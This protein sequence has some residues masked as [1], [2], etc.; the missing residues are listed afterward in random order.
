M[1][2]KSVNFEEFGLFTLVQERDDDQ[3]WED[4]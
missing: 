2:V 1:A 3:L 4:N